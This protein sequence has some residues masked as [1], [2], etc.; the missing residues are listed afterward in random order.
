MRQPLRRFRVAVA[1]RD[2]VYEVAVAAPETDAPDRDHLVRPFVGAIA[3]TASTKDALANPGYPPIRRLP[4]A[5][6][7]KRALIPECR[8]CDCRR[9]G[10]RRGWRKAGLE[11]AGLEEGGVGGRRGW[12]KAGWRKAGWRKAG[13]EEGGAGGRRVGGRRGWRKAGLEEGGVGGR[14]GWRRWCLEEVVGGRDPRRVML[15]PSSTS[16]ERIPGR[17]GHETCVRLAS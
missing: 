3:M 17:P 4:G 14:R 16:V 13:L 6:C 2:R 9:V 11:E 1:G 15:L 5:M 8:P 10:G 12:R 7:P